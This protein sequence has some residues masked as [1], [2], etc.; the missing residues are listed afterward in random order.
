M[1]DDAQV[2]ENWAIN[3]RKEGDGGG[4]IYKNTFYTKPD[5]KITFF[6]QY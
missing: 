6:R 1:S 3:E 4:K 5:K 2:S